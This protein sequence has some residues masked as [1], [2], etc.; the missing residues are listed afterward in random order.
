MKQLGMGRNTRRCCL[1]TAVVIA[2][3]LLSGLALASPPIEDPSAPQALACDARIAELTK[4][5]ASSSLLGTIILIFGASL[6][7]VGCA[8]AGFVQH[9]GLRRAGAVL[10]VGGAIVAILPRIVPHHAALEA[11]LRAADR[12]RTL[13]VGINS[14]I[15]FLRDE[16]IIK[17]SERYV[18]ARFEQCRSPRPDLELSALPRFSA[19]AARTA[20]PAA[21]MELP[22]P[23]P[24]PEVAPAALASVAVPA[25]TDPDTTTAQVTAQVA[26][27]QG[28][29]PSR[30]AIEKEAVQ[31]SAGGPARPAQAS[32][33]A[34]GPAFDR[35]A[36]VSALNG[37]ASS[38]A[39]CK[40]PDGPTG[41]GR[42]AVTFSPGGNAATATVEGPPFAGTPVGGCVAAWFRAAHVPPFGGA[43]V[44]V[45]KTFVIQ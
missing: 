11:S 5:V 21:E 6:A 39:S 29:T 14:E 22:V 12:H 38:V 13:A 10:G 34:D 36:A 17:Q 25:P 19:G 32:A 44:T 8:L 33:G 7:G 16:E 9:G 4:A 1:L 20:A 40:K 30:P 3:V 35:E 2:T 28:A 18:A 15:P 45:R 27:R 31:P 42:V 37:A 24:T 26:Q 41:T 43:A 23:A